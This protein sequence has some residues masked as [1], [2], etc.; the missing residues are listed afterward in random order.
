MKDQPVITVKPV[1]E[2]RDARQAFS[3]KASYFP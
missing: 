1:K 3:R 2:F